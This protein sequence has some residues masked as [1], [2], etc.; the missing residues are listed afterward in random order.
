MII[1]GKKIYGGLGSYPVHPVLLTVA[2]LSASWPSRF[3]YT[4]SVIGKDWGIKMIEPL[5]LIKTLGNSAEQVFSPGDLI[6]GN[7]VAG[8]GNA[9]VIWLLIGGI[10]LLLMKEIT[11]HI[12]L[13]FLSG[14][15]IM[16]IILCLVDSEKFTSAHFHLLSGSTV[17]AAFFLATEHTTSPVNN[18]P[19]LLYGLLGGCLLVIIRSFSVYYDGIAYTILLINLCN[20][21]LDAITPKI[22]GVE[23]RQNA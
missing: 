2:M 3:D 5:R 1:F 12:P 4:L 20:P 19:M 21:L 13:S 7:Q 9:M 10:F 8:L 17:F 23:V 15:F 14:V 6:L 22:Q 18:I 11:W 16:A